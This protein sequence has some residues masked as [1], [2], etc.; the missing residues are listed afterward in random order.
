MKFL[1]KIKNN[2]TLSK[3]EEVKSSLDLDKSD[4]AVKDEFLDNKRK[5]E[6]ESEVVYFLIDVSGSM[7]GDKIIEAKRGVGDF[8]ANIQR[9]YGEKK[10]LVGLVAFNKEVKLISTP[11]NDFEL[12]KDNIKPLQAGGSTNLT[13]AIILAMNK[14]DKYKMNRT[15]CIFTDGMPDDEESALKAAKEAKMRGIVLLAVG[16]NDAKF[17]FLKELTGT[18]ERVIQKSAKELRSAIGELAKLL[19]SN[20][21]R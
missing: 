6:Q 18:S 5:I 16:T 13:D 9:M 12:I 21:H 3:V 19:P 20:N 4:Q 8:L 7:C 11:T 15:I 17:D 2:I 10:Y 1:E 14:L